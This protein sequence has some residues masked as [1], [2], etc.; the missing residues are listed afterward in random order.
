MDS[1]LAVSPGD[2]AGGAN[3]IMISGFSSPLPTGMNSMASQPLSGLNGPSLP[4]FWGCMVRE[5]ERP[6]SANCPELPSRE[7]SLW[8]RWKFYW[9]ITLLSSSEGTGCFLLVKE[10]KQQTT[11]PI[12][13][14]NGASERNSAQLYSKVTLPKPNQTSYCL[15]QQIIVSAKYCLFLPVNNK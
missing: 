14:Q 9:E 10:G 13:F 6:T 12:P 2:L 7:K 3:C 8:W 11:C 4:L 5:G 1:R 15:F